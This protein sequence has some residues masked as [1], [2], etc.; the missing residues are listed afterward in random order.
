MFGTLDVSVSGMIAQR[1]R[2]DVLSSNIANKDTIL[3]ADG[4]YSPFRRR[5]AVLAPGDPSRGS[6]DGVHVRQ[7]ELDD[8]PFKKRFEPGS[9]YADE[10]GYV[11]YP[12][13]DSTHEMINAMSASRSYEANITV[14]E[15][16][17]SMMQS[18]L[19]L[20]G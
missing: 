8:A 4:N 3:N 10:S 12:N 1:T 5:L 7:I 17:K 16:T 9:P 2:M 14:A 18:N 13:I 20:L 6:G 15:S 11:E 19:R